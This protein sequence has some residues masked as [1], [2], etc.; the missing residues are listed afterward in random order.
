MEE[1]TEGGALRERAKIFKSDWTKL[2][3]EWIGK[4]LPLEYDEFKQTFKF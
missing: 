2:N 4:W 3:P 1:K